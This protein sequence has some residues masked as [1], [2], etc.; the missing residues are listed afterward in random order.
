MGLGMELRTGIEAEL[1]VGT[2]GGGATA[3]SQ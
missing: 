2:R 1:P 3:M